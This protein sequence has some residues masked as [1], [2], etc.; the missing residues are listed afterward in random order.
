MYVI[1]IPAAIKP[2]KNIDGIVWPI[3]AEAS[4]PIPPDALRLAV[5]AACGGLQTLVVQ[6]DANERYAKSHPE[7]KPLL[8]A[9][10]IGLWQTAIPYRTA[11]V[12]VNDGTNDLATV[13]AIVGREVH[14]ITPGGRVPLQHEC[15]QYACDVTLGTRPQT[16]A[17]IVCGIARAHPDKP[18]LGAIMLKAHRDELLPG[19]DDPTAS[20]PR[21]R[22]RRRKRGPLLPR[23]IRRRIEWH[24]HYGSGLDR[25]SNDMHERVDLAIVAGTF[26]PPPHEVRRRLVEMGLVEEAHKGDRWGVIERHARRPDGTTITYTGLGYA[27]EA[28]RRAAES[29]S[30][31]AVRQAIGRARANTSRGAAVVAVTTE[32][33]GLPVLPAAALPRSKPEIERIAEAVGAARSTSAKSAINNNSGFGT[34]C[35]EPGAT[36][37]A[38]QARLPR[39]PRRTLLRWLATAVEAGAVIRTGHTTATRYAMPQPPERPHGPPAVGM[40]AGIERCP[41]CGSGEHRDTVSSDGQ[42]GRL[43]C[44]ECGAFVRFTIWHGNRVHP[45]ATPPPLSARVLDVAATLQE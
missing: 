43:A 5:A 29:L 16:V 17:N 12:I 35:P 14:D 6:V 9:R 7:A 45:R 11:A 44:A 18:R 26:R 25:G 19:D 23:A 34:S 13:Q 33:T 42:I 15:V 39:V 30:R 2:P 8:R 4:E 22:G 27:S 3:M 36:L 20:G 28:W 40:A 38:V 31:A 32:A 37:A 1:P 21:R 41:S 10:A 24:T